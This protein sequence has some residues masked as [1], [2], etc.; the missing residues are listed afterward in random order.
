MSRT[1]LLAQGDT[2]EVGPASIHRLAAGPREQA[3]YFSEAFLGVRLRCANCHNHPLDR[4][5]QD[6]YHG[7]AAIFAGVQRG[8]IIRLTQSGEVVHPRTGEA[9]MAK[10]PA[11]PILNGAQRR[12]RR[13][14]SKLKGRARANRTTRRLADIEGEP[15]VRQGDRESAV[16]RA[17]G[18][19]LVEP[20]D[21]LR[22][23]NPGVHAKLLERLAEDFRQHDHNLRRTLKLIA[24]SAAFRRSAINPHPLADGG[25]YARFAT[26]P[27]QAEVWLDAIADATG[28]P[29][30]FGKE[31]QAARAVLL[32]DPLAENDSLD[33]I[34][35]CD[36][37]DSCDSGGAGASD[38]RVRLHLINGPLLNAR[39]SSPQGKLA[40]WLS[41]DAKDPNEILKSLY[42]AALARYPRDDELSFWRKEIENLTRDEQRSFWEDAF[43]SVLCSDEFLRY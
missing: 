40:E 1:M 14:A 42:L 22:N 11:G 7:L 23:S 20:V 9:A 2:H 16:A 36:R 10:I 3:E 26:S 39:L 4:W 31:Q 5:T 12:F 13:L 21:D 25:Y 27:M 33:V 6:D 18:R 37:Q 8:R 19:G 28:V 17:H 43:W 34:G 41:N 29:A 24:Q 15:L 32:Q 35:R 30:V 38:L